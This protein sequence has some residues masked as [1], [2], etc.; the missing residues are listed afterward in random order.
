MYFDKYDHTIN[1]NIACRHHK[2]TG[3]VQIYLQPTLGVTQSGSAL[4]YVLTGPVGPYYP[5]GMNPVT[6]MAD[7]KFVRAWPGGCGHFKM[8]S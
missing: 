6:L 2:I 3:Q 8:G 1:Q 5:T 4:L 7:P